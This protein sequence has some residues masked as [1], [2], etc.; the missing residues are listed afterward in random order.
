M[1]A[2]LTMNRLN[3][4]DNSV[5]VRVPP[6]DLARLMYY[7]SCVYD[8]FKCEELEPYIDYKNYFLLYDID[9]V[10]KFARIFNPYVMSKCKLFIHDDDLDSPNKFYKI[11]DETYGIHFNEEILISGRVAKVSTIMFFNSDWFCRYYL[12]PLDRLTSPPLDTIPGNI[13]TRNNDYTCDDA[14]CSCIIF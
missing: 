8:V 6:N 1:F 11:T 13:Y 2:N 7:L 14:L 12:N 10:I 5:T 3:I 4:K 9:D